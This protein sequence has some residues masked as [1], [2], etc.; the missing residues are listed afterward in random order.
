MDEM[1]QQ[2]AALVEE[3]TA[4]LQSAQGQVDELQRV[5]A[6][7]KTGDEPVEVAAAPAKPPVKPAAK[8]PAANPVHKQQRK[9]AKK[10]AAAGG[11]AAA[12]QAED[13]QEF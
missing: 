13:W 9:V 11:G 1:T 10:V 8:R 7:F 2:N 4:A 5:V 6:F 12:A 3:T